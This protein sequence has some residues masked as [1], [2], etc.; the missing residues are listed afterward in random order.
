[1]RKPIYRFWDN[2]KIFGEDTVFSYISSNAHI[3]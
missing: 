3:C 1:M 2:V